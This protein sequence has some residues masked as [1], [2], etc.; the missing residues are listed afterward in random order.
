MQSPHASLSLP[1]AVGVAR[2]EGAGPTVVGVLRPDGVSLTV[3][4]VNYRGILGSC[5]SVTVQWT[6]ITLGI[7]TSRYGGGIVGIVEPLTH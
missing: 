1:T 3:V 5:G 4:G 7:L 2:P 6:L